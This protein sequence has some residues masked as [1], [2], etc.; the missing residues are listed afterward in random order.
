M[1][2]FQTQDCTCYVPWERSFRYPFMCLISC[3][4]KLTVSHSCISNAQIPNFMF[5]HSFTV[6]RKKCNFEVIECHMEHT[7]K[8]LVLMPNCQSDMM[9]FEMHS[10]QLHTKTDLPLYYFINFFTYFFSYSTNSLFVR[11][12]NAH[13]IYHGTGHLDSH[14]W[15]HLV[16][17][18][19]CS[20]ISNTLPLRF[21]FSQ[22][23]HGG[24]C[25]CH[26]TG[27]YC[28]NQMV[29]DCFVIWA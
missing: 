11:R 29:W 8:K 7:T 22:S 26:A 12:K 15:Y 10:N 5:S 24:M 2:I 13:V 1:C 23:C 14:L 3:N 17:T 4:L 27:T 6:G 9:Q 28:V 18:V 21:L 19:S 20:C 16:T 25:V